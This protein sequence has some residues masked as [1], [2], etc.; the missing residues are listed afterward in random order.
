MQRLLHR[1]VFLNNEAGFNITSLL[2]SG[3]VKTN[4]LDFM[5]KIS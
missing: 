1:L 4:R 2:I 5:K 3:K